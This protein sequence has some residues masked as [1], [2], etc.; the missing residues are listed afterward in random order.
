M[1]TAATYF[2]LEWCSSQVP[3]GAQF[4]ENRSNDD[5]ER[6]FSLL[7][8]DNRENLDGLEH[9]INNKQN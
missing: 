3:V 1:I 7:R 4:I 2:L 9:E 5:V 6:F 8:F